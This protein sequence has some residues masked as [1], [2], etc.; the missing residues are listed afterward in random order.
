[1]DAIVERATA[2][3]RVLLAGGADAVIVENFGDTPFDGDEVPPWTVAAMTRVCLAVRAA[4]PPLRLGVNVLRNDARAALSVAHAAG[5]EFIRVNVHVGAMVTDQGLLQGKARATLLERNRLGATVRIV[6]DVRV[7]HAVPLGSPELADL[8]R[9]TADRGLADVLVVTGSGT[10]RHTDPTDWRVVR[11][12]TSRPVWVGSGFDPA[13]AGAFPG[14]EGA[15]VGTWLHEGSAIDA[16]LSL[17][18]VRLARTALDQAAANSD[19]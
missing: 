1:L 7:K 15:I 12:A 13:G 9:D 14:L 11:D 17:E 16:P 5:G 19:S 18:R 8:A 10:G 6:A 2:D 3:A 4:A